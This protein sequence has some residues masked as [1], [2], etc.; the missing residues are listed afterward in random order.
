MVAA[1]NSGAEF[2]RQ[3]DLFVK[4][5][6]G[7]GALRLL[8]QAVKQAAFQNT[9]HIR[10]PK[11]VSAY[12][13]S[14][15][16][17]TAAVYMDYIDGLHPLLPGSYGRSVGAIL[18]WVLDNYRRGRNVN[19]P[20]EVFSAKLNSLASVLPGSLLPHL[21]R[22]EE[23]FRNGAVL[24]A[25]VTHGDLTFCNMLVDE[26]GTLWL[27]DF[28]DPFIDVVEMDMA[29]LRQDTA[30]GWAGLFTAIPASHAEVADTMLNPAFSSL[31]SMQEHGDALRL[32][33]LLRAFPYSKEERVREHILRRVECIRYS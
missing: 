3:G 8:I 23:H 30:D 22:L 15:P 9:E 31:P 5:A 4:K 27:Y 29:K 11:V 24:R 25:G 13:S 2:E 32:L 18:R 7:D 17:T 26:S 19:V 10:A 14:R 16:Q 28:L 1:G 21:Q 20:R 6:A 33:N 12:Y